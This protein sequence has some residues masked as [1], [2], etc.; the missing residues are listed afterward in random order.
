MNLNVAC[1]RPFVGAKNEAEIELGCFGDG[2]IWRRLFH[3]PFDVIASH[4][5]SSSLLLCIQ[6]ADPVS[7]AEQCPHHLGPFSLLVLHS[8]HHFHCSLSMSNR[9]VG[10]CPN[11]GWT[12]TQH[13]GGRS[14]SMACSFG[15]PRDASLRTSHDQDEL[16]V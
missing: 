1:V 11:H 16:V 2:R 15:F 8:L 4:F 10:A 7:P 3:Q 5:L 12:P 9:S 6:N 14:Y 13:L